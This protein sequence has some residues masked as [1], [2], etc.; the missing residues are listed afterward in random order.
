MCL[1]T[2]H[3]KQQYLKKIMEEEL[4]VKTCSR[5]KL[6]AFLLS[7]LVP[8]LGQLYNG[9]FRK[10]VIYSISLL[11]LPIGFNIFGLKQYFWAYAAVIILLFVLRLLIPIEAA[12]I[13]DRKSVV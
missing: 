10:S 12:L 7:A 9:Q 8:G 13:A 11:S 2:K 3:E 6:L 1:T 4:K 5:K